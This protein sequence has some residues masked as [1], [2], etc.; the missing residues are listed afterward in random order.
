MCRVGFHLRMRPVTVRPKLLRP[1]HVAPEAVP[2]AG[3]EAH[4]LCSITALSGHPG[5]RLSAMLLPVFS[6][7][8]DHAGQ[9]TASKWGRQ[10]GVE[11]RSEL[12][13][14]GGLSVANK[15]PD[16]PRTVERYR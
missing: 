1:C 8:G 9:R 10:L 4:G 5:P 15:F 14:Q 7:S 3:R 12:L 11:G 2:D 6:V 16:F 13:R